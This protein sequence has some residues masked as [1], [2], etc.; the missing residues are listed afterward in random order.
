MEPSRIE[1]QIERIEEV[2]A[3]LRKVIME[4]TLPGL[5]ELIAEL[6]SRLKTLLPEGDE[7]PAEIM[8]YRERFT[9]IVE[10]NA[11]LEGLMQTQLKLISNRL[12]K[13]KDS[14]KLLT[15]YSGQSSKLRQFA[16]RSLDVDG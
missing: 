3:K 10:R 15:M 11:Q 9:R 4:D 8:P 7:L 2:Q 5:E 13:T 1:Q 16:K 14:Q 6:G 12:R